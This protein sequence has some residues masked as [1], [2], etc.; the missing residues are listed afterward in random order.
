MTR[1]LYEGTVFDLT[2]GIDA[3]PFGDPMRY[4]PL[5]RWNSPTM[6]VTYE[7]Y[8]KGLGFQR[9]IS[10]WRTSYAAVTQSRASLP[11]EVGAVTWLA[12]YAPHHSSFIPIYASPDHAPSVLKKGSLY[13]F[14]RSSNWW[15][16]CM[17]SNYISKWYRYTLPDVR[18]LQRSIETTLF[19]RQPTVEMEAVKKL[20]S[21]G[22]VAS[23]LMLEQYHESSAVMVRDKWWDFFFDMVSH[24]FNAYSFAVHVRFAPFL[25]YPQ[26]LFSCLFTNFEFPLLLQVGKYHDMYRINYPFNANFLAT[27][28]YLSVPRWY[29]EQIGYWG[30]PGSPPPGEEHAMGKNCRLNQPPLKMLA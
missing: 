6:G 5:F 21:E 14:E 8:T 29:Y 4:G 18:K 9:P 23:K 26:R 30:A 25:Q 13:Y 15:I 12:Q 2:T 17:V 24:L 3:G 20:A 1:D 27:Y 11:D 22:I 16:H 7:Q 19:S 28:S 10:L